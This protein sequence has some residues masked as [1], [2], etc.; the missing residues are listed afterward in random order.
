MIGTVRETDLLVGKSWELHITPHGLALTAGGTAPA[1]PNYQTARYYEV[2]SVLIGP[3]GKQLQV[4]FS[5]DRPPWVIAGVA[6]P[7]ALWAQATIEQAAYHARMREDAAFSAPLSRAD[8]AKRI[9]ALAGGVSYEAAVLADLILTQA[10]LAK[11]TDV[12]LKPTI[13]ALVIRY[14]I[15]GQLVEIAQVP[16]TMGERIVARTKVMG[17]MKTYM[18]NLP[19]TG[20]MT[21][22]VAGR[23]VDIRLTTLPTT[24]GEKL[25]A[26]V[27]DPAT[28]A[29][30]LET[31]GMEPAAL[32][33]FLAMVA[34]PQ[35]CIILTGPAGSGKTSTMYASLEQILSQGTPRS[36]STV[37][38]PVEFI[39]PGADQT[40][41]DRD[42][43]LDFAG[44]LR[45]VLRQDPQVIMVGEIRDLETAQIAAQAGLTGHLVFS[46]VHAASSAGVFARL[47]EIG[48][49]PYLVA[50]SLTAVVA[51][52]LVRQVC[53]SCARPYQPAPAELEAA[54]LSGRRLDGWSFVRAVGCAECGE[55][56]YAGRT[57]VFELLPVTRA[58]RK[59]VVERCAAPDLEA[60]AAEEGTQ[61]LWMAGL[62]KVRA[63]ITT[64]AE[65]HIVLGAPER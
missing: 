13:D 9:T 20:R 61:T 54:G 43:G 19:Q 56:G 63:G 27:F 44:G 65:L 12:H 50:S 59:A 47:V 62:E 42:A 5:G 30:G 34:R 29:L 36:I 18:R 64:L 37:E 57:G 60:M 15:D 40:E 46:T 55:T 3:G 33:R 21:L 28:R 38:E 58:L 39:I 11:A 53:R 14:R 7:E 25:T 24:G 51:Q 52:R 26:R 2:E 32:E 4:V 35:G 31:L 6:R 48:L 8:L 17:E 10:A 1:D 16:A 41:V 23:T 22:E 45:T 49:E